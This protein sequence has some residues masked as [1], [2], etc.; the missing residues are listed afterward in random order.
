MS[1]S[2]SIRRFPRWV[3]W[4]GL[5]TLVFVLSGA[6]VAAA[7]IRLDATRSSELL[8]GVR[9]G[10]VKLDG[11]EFHAARKA[12]I[13]KFESPLNRPITVEAAGKTFRTSPRAL[14]ASTDVLPVLDRAIKFHRSMP[15]LQR[16]WYRISGISIS[17]NF[18]VATRLDPHKA[19]PFIK[20]IEGVVNRQ[21]VNATVA[22]SDGKIK[23]TNEASGYQLDPQSAQ[24]RLVA[25]AR[26]GKD[27]VL[28]QGKDLA[29]GIRAADFKDVLVVKVGENKLFHYQSAN[30]L[31]VYDVATGEAKFPTPKGQFKIVSKR[32]NPTWVNPAKKPGGWGEKLPE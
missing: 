6:G 21:P 15:M 16:A 1:G 26:A 10:E 31:K 18:S 32:K 25:A 4:L 28:L 11:M 30:L 20:K 5:P 2:R 8:K 24:R 14:G 9:V 23:V 29:P 13:A 7:A 19:G 3:F 22:Y 17:R 27:S 12:L